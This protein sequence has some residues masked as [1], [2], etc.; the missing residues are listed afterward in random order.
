MLLIGGIA[1]HHLHAA[2][3]I[4]PTW[5]DTGHW[6]LDMWARFDAR[7]YLSIATGGYHYLTDAQS[8]VPFFPLYPSLMWLIGHLFGGSR[9]ALLAAGVLISNVAL[10]GACS[11][12]W[13]LARLDFEDAVADRSVLYLLVFPTTV[14]LSAIY[15]ESLFLLLILGSFYHAR[16]GQ[17]GPAGA[18]A[19]LAAL[20]RPNGVLI[21]LPLALE[22]WEQRRLSRN[23]VRPDAL[24]LAAA[25]AALGGWLLCLGRLTGDPFSFLHAEKFWGRGTTTLWESL[26]HPLRSAY[27]GSLAWT[28]A[29]TDYVFTWFFLSLIVVSWRKV[30]PSYALFGGL[31]L[32][33]AAYSGVFVSMPR[34]GLAFFS[35]F[36]LLALF[37]RRAGFHRAWLVA[38]SG[39]ACVFTA[40]FCLWHWVA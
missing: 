35:V 15:T 22:Y 28:H 24:W 17:W 25:P 23:G 4:P 26:T 34:Y 12:L 3:P 8:N 40:M 30:R 2:Q 38:S 39:L 20:A 9:T 29:L 6:W 11:Y 14:F 18:F 5:R 27:P 31:C 37:G 7:W 16:R 19:A 32:A 33:V 13:R 36:P 1:M 21:A 10:L